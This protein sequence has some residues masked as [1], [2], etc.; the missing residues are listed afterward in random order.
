[1]SQAH[2]HNPQELM[3]VAQALIQQGN[4]NNAVVAYHQCMNQ[5]PD[6]VPAYLHLSHYFLALNTL[7]CLIFIRVMLVN[8]EL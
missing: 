6:F 7:A 5:F 2:H 1:M 4:V 3:R 8:P